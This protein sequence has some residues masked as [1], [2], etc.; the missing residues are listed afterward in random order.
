MKS[1]YDTISPRELELAKKQAATHQLIQQIKKN[2]AK[3]KQKNDNKKRTT[4]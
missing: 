4:K 2:K 1:I 3:A